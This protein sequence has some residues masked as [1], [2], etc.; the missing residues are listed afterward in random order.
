MTNRKPTIRIQNIVASA[1]LDQRISLTKI[2]EKFPFAEYSP[3]VFP[4]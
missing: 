2:V 3:R 1:A 4:D